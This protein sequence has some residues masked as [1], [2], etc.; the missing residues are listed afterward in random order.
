[1][2]CLLA[3]VVL[4]VV[5][6]RSDFAGEN[7]WRQGSAMPQASIRE[8]DAIV[9]DLMS[10]PF[11]QAVEQFT[12]LPEGIKSS[13]EAELVKRISFHEDFIVHHSRILKG[14]S[15]PVT[16]V[17]YDV[18][19]NFVISGSYDNTVRVWNLS[20]DPIVSFELKGH[21]SPVMSVAFSPSTRYALSGDQDG[22][23]RLWDLTHGTS[24]E[25][26]GHTRSVI[27]LSMSHDGNYALSAGD[28]RTV[29][30]W[31]LSKNHIE[32]HVVYAGEV[33]SVAFRPD[34]TW[35][36][37]GEEDGRIIRGGL[38]R[39]PVTLI[40]GLKGFSDGGDTPNV[41]LNADES[42]CI[43]AYDLKVRLWDVNLQRSEDL[44]EHSDGAVTCVA[45]SP[46]GNYVVSGAHDDTLR[47]CDVRHKRR[48]VCVL[49]G[50]THGISSV[51]MSPEGKNVISASYDTTLRLWKVY[52]DGL[53]AL[54]LIRMDQKD[55][56][57]AHSQKARELICDLPKSL[58]VFFSHAG[59]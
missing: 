15:R 38:E 49:K 35:V 23:L 29:R 37:F 21:T 47:L 1:M 20:I 41:A 51:A 52:P 7:D 18:R 40:Q 13:V 11:D 32:S 24:Q 3:L 44:T 25:F 55:R 56:S 45:Y 36:I 43:S 14:H 39:H 57:L 22:N 50:H 30:L 17:A 53:T 4:A 31:D 46:D 6:S 58:Q 9:Q 59:L 10:R 27:S 42:H 12:Q 34:D 48:G 28:D 5:L 2:K 8:I 16:S 26:I 54:L 33:S 19:G